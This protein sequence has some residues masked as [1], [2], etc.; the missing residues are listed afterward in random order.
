MSKTKARKR[1]SGGGLVDFDC[2]EAYKKALEYEL[3]SEV[4]VTPKMETFM[5]VIAIEYC[6]Y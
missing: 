2:K 4:W 3:S 1:N 6:A 5:K